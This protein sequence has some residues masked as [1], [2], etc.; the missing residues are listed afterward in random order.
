MFYGV[1]HVVVPVSSVDEALPL[2]VSGLGFPLHERGESWADVE[3][4][5]T[6]LRLQKRSGPIERVTLRIQTE[7]L[8]A[9]R[10]HLL[11]AGATADGE[12]ERTPELELCCRVIDRDGHVLVL[13]RALT[14]DEYGFDPE[15][16]S[17]G[18]WDPRA[19]E[20]LKLIL[21][22]VPVLFRHLA[23]VKI[24]RK[25]EALS[26]GIVDE[27]TVIR[28]SIMSTARIMRDTLRGPLVDAGVDLDKYKEE[29]DY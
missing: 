27:H 8:E 4:A 9:G 23:R 1:S 29:F 21:R 20:F 18:E 2:Y 22:R 5:S 16:P 17:E 3:G 13:W 6:F 14:E 15:I 11:Q 28:A 19:E 26:V 7:D 25:A 24:T 10:M 12:I